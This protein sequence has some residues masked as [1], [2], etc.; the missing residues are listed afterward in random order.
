MLISPTKT[1]SDQ[2]IIYG[3]KKGDKLII[4]KVYQ[5]YFFLISNYIKKNSGSTEDA[6][7]IF[8]EAL[9]IIYHNVSRNNF[10]LHCKFS[11][12]LFS[13]CK[14]LWLKHLRDHPE[15]QGDH[16]DLHELPAET[17]PEQAI[18]EAELY[19][20][21]LK[22]FN[23]LSNKCQEVLQMYFAK[24][25]MRSIAESLNLSSESYAKKK[26]FKCKEQLI[27]NIK[28]ELLCLKNWQDG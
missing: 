2:L 7:D 28:E 27:R 16:I 21:Y 15:K 3:I 20:V 19:E 12:Y 18:R 11:T 6:K 22:K 14:N 4:E 26:K 24:I 9:I 5:E 25:D 1:E 13:I 23:T 8:Q 17:N 10:G